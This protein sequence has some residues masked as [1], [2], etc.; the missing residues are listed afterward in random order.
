LPEIVGDGDA[1]LPGPPGDVLLAAALKQLLDKPAQRATMGRTTRTRAQSRYQ[2]SAFY[3]EVSQR[4]LSD[5]VS[6]T[7]R[8]KT[9]RTP[10]PR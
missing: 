1:S 10:L 9:S 5:F 8:H 3:G 4:V 2:Q 7:R 6:P